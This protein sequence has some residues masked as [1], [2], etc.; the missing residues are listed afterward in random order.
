MQKQKSVSERCQVNH[1]WNQV[2][3]EIFFSLLFSWENSYVVECS[4]RK[5][6]MGWLVHNIC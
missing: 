2:M 3:F 4:E 1:A 6:V 5:A